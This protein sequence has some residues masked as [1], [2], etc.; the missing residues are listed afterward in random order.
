[1][2]GLPPSALQKVGKT[3]S[4]QFG[5]SFG[6]QASSFFIGAP[7]SLVDLARAALAFSRFAYAVDIMNTLTLGVGSGLDPF[8]PACCVIVAAAP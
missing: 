2:R 4:T 8:G 3:L 5:E 1:M 6:F 7:E